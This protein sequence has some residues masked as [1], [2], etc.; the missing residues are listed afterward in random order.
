M[1]HTFEARVAL[2]NAKTLLHCLAY[3]TKVEYEKVVFMGKFICD[4]CGKIF[5]RVGNKRYKHYFCCKKCEAEFRRGKLT[6]PK[7]LNE[8]IIEDKYAIIKIQ[9]NQLGNFDCLIDIEDVDKIKDYFWNIRYD[10]RHPKCTVYVETHRNKKRIHLHRLLTN[11]PKNM[12]VDHID[13]NGLDNRKTN[14]RVV[15][16]R[17][18]CINRMLSKRNLP[19]GVYKDKRSKSEKYITM[20]MGKYI[21]RFKNIEEAS[22]AYLKAKNAYFSTIYKISE[23]YLPPNT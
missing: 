20:F 13:G 23:N 1:Y 14:L 22:D 11:C 17:N 9:N 12:V 3:I 8:I 16:Q 2:E 19:I 6:R 7:K 10:K 15:T 4:Y 21:G 5:E 18:N